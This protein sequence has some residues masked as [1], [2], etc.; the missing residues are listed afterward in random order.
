MRKSTDLL[1]AEFPHRSQLTNPDRRITRS[2]ASQMRHFMTPL[3][4][5]AMHEHADATPVD[6]TGVAKACARV[7][8]TCEGAIKCRICVSMLCVSKSLHE[9]S[10]TRSCVEIA[11]AADLSIYTCTLLDVAADLS[12]QACMVFAD[13]RFDLCSCKHV[14]T[15]QVC[16]SA[17]C[18]NQ[19]RHHLAA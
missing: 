11:H 19:V 6:A 2:I 7:A 16:E 3:H 12:I 13:C 5:D 8:S 4:V 17:A 9:D 15:A 14:V 10:S 1:H 18:W